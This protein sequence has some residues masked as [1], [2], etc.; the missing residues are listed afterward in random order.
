MV[1]LLAAFLISLQQSSESPGSDHQLLL[2]AFISPKVEWRTHESLLSPALLSQVRDTL[3]HRFFEPDWPYPEFGVNCAIVA[4]KGDTAIFLET[5]YEL[6][7]T[8]RIFTLQNGKPQLLQEYDGY[9]FA[10]KWDQVGRI[11]HI[12]ICKIPA[13][14]W[15]CYSVQQFGFANSSK[16]VGLVPEQS[17]TWSMD[18]DVKGTPQWSKPSRFHILMSSYNLRCKPLVDPRPFDP[19]YEQNSNSIALYEKGDRGIAIGDKADA[20][21]RIW[22]LVV[23]ESPPKTKLRGIKESHLIG[24]MSSRYLRQDP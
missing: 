2:H 13:G 18:S 10:V 9:V 7:H 23:I 8:T 1:I 24:W 5:A 20:T 3:H 11:G 6:G 12:L 4:P 21:G 16:G 19:E 22:W 15:G 14:D 17:Y